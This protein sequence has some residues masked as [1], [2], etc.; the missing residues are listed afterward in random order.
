VKLWLAAILASL[1]AAAYA[2]APASSGDGIGKTYQG[3]EI[4]RVMGFEGA[5]WLERP[6]RETEERPDMLVA[7]LSL[8]KGMNIADVGAGSGYLS[9]R[10]APSIAPGK[11]Y[12]VDVQ[13]E[14]VQMLKNLSAKPATANVIPVLGSAGNVNLPRDSIDLAIM[15]DTYHELSQPREI[16]QSLL[17]ALKPGGRLVL[18]EYRGEDPQVPIKALHK[19]TLSQ[20]RLEMRQ[21]PLTFERADERLPLQHIV[22]LTKN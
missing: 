4:A 13:P 7:A 20:I 12:A 22:F 15:V 19:M 17:A 5:A 3:R 9:K 6:E 18:V 1:A 16:L 11:L 2:Q 10:M 14:M 8:R 21:F